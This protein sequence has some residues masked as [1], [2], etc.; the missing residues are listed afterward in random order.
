MDII[1]INNN[2]NN[3]NKKYSYMNINNRKIIK[4]KSI[5]DRIN[6][7]NIPPNYDI[8]YIN[9]NPYHKHQAICD[10]SKGRKQ[11][12]YHE[13]YKK[14]SKEIKFKEL[15]IFGKKIKKIRSDIN[16]LLICNDTVPTKDNV[17]GAVF[18]LIDKCNFR[19]GSVKYKKQYNTYGTTTLNIDHFIFKKGGISINFIGKKNVTNISYITN[20]KCIDIISKLCKLYQNKEFIFCYKDNNG[21]S[22]HVTENQINSFLKKYHEDLSVKMFRTWTANSVL[23]KEFL[24]RPIPRTE[25][26]RLNNIRDSIKKA[27][28]EL[29]HTPSVSKKAYINNELIQLYLNKNKL[30]YELYNKFNKN[31]SSTNDSILNSFLIY[32]VKK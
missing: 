16:K 10:D 30:F 19:I 17:M 32:I 11:Y 29:H 6:K 12:I 23:L 7:L 21:R 18:Y 26:E 14:H 25:R 8:V 13:N 24:S 5:L 31:S 2:K 22:I 3:S 1:R 20:K 28:K 9:T 27:A 4:T 15:I